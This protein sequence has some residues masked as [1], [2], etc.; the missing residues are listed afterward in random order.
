MPWQM[1]TRFNRQ[2]GSGAGYQDLAA[3]GFTNLITTWRHIGLVD[4]D[5]LA[6][7]PALRSLYP[8]IVRQRPRQAPARF[9]DPLKKAQEL[10]TYAADWDVPVAV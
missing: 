10:Y 7:Q 1:R 3:V 2:G 9:S 8:E 6:L 4:N 5:E